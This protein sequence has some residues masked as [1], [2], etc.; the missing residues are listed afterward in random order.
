MSGVTDSTVRALLQEGLLESID[1][2]S[3]ELVAAPTPNAAQSIAIEAI[4]DAITSRR[5]EPFLLFGVTGSG[6]TEV[7]L[8][9]AAAALAAGRQVLY[10]VPEIALATQAITQVRSRFGRGVAV[11]HSELTVLERLRA[12]SQIAAGEVG[13]VIGPR[14]ALFAPLTNLGLIVMDEEHEGAYKQDQ[15]PRYHARTLARELSELHDCPV[16]LGSAT[17]SFE[18][19]AAAERGEITLASLPSR[20]ATARLPEITI[21]DLTQTYRS[22]KPSLLVPELSDAIREALHSNA[23]V[24]LFLNRRAYSPFVICRDC[25]HRPNCPHCSVS[26]SYHRSARKVRCHQ[27]GFSASEPVLCPS[28]QGTRLKPLGIG[29][30]KVE[31]VLA[32]E[33]PEAKIGRL[34]R[35]VAT[36]KG[37]I[38]SVLSSF[39]SG[40]LN[41][42]IG[43]QMVAKGLDFPRVTVVGV[44]AADI[45]LSIPDFRSGE[46]TFQLLSQVSGRAGRG[47]LPGRVF[48]Q[49]FSPD[50]PAVDFVQRHDFVGFF[51]HSIKEREMLRYPPYSHLVNLIVTSVTKESAVAKSEEIAAALRGFGTV[52]GPADCPIEKLNNRY[53]RHLLVKLDSFLEV[54]QV[55]Q[56]VSRIEPGKCSIVVDVDPVN[57]S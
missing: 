41:I 9:A 6:K 17:P 53:R 57:F 24:I 27:C 55:G 51:Q 13:L 18:S 45:S 43:T 25:G 11:L 3:P 47:E 49:T 8:R 40:D 4:T 26:L 30:E 44:I 23:Q 54:E 46:R 19:F 2:E 7:Y 38:E 33:F 5:A 52:L 12:W 1:P 14:S 48:I 56:V 39:R 15:S 29:T 32:V 22:G 36:Q 37:A 31:E 34:D 21:C 50:H 20:T 28:C 35:D 16:V 42:L 10:L